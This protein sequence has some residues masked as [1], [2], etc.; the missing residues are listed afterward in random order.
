MAATNKL[1]ALAV[2]QAKPREKDY[3]VD[4]LSVKKLTKKLSSI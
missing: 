1:T 2:R 4:D 3:K